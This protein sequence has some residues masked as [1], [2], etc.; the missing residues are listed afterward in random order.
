MTDFERS[1]YIISTVAAHMR[2]KKRRLGDVK[3]AH[4]N[5][6][7]VRFD[8]YVS[9]RGKGR[10]NFPAELKRFMK[11]YLPEIKF[12]RKA[13]D[14]FLFRME[15]SD[16]AWLMFEVEKIFGYGVGKQFGLKL[17]CRSDAEEHIV[18]RSSI[19]ELFDREPMCWVYGTLDDLLSC[20]TEMAELIETVLP[21]LR[22]E[23]LKMLARPHESFRESLPKTG[24]LDF[25]E[26][27][28][29]ARDYCASV[30][31]QC[32]TVFGA[33][34]SFPDVKLT[35]SGILQLNRTRPSWGWMI[36]MADRNSAEYINVTIPI[37]G[38]PIFRR[39]FG[40][41]FASNIRMQRSWYERNPDELLALPDTCMDVSS[42]DPPKTEPEEYL[43]SSEIWQGF[44][45]RAGS[46][47]MQTDRVYR[48]DIQLDA[49]DYCRKQRS[50]CWKFFLG[51]GPN[52]EMRQASHHLYLCFSARDG[53]RMLETNL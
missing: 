35:K 38:M 15:I 11:E 33:S 52:E 36:T 20:F 50:E 10:V 4:H 39:G 24:E 43:N 37:F 32:D 27:K 12:Q 49:G 14:N 46:F 48:V 40:G 34:A 3:N 16:T 5:S 17:I 29:L 6:E 30:L 13:G 45:E 44:A 42:I 2:K 19:F 23:L 47:G 7:A 41:A 1:N 53:E 25:F 8:D 28:N 18:Y 9:G 21:A 51:S 22:E 26:A 31:P